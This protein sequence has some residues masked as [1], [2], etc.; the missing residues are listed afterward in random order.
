MMDLVLPI[1]KPIYS[2]YTYTDNSSASLADAKKRF[3]ELPNT[4]Y[5]VLDISKD[6]A[7]QGFENNE[8]DL[9]VATNAIHATKS[10]SESLANVRKLLA[11]NG[12]FL[13]QELHPQSK[14]I[15][16][17]FGLLDD[18]WLGEQDGRSD[19]PYVGSARWQS[20]LQRAGFTVPVTVLDSEEPHQLNALMIAKPVVISPKPIS[21]A[22]TILSDNNVKSAEALFQQLQCRGYSVDLCQLGDE[23]PESQDIISVLDESAPFFENTS[24]THFKAFQQLLAKLGKSGL[25]WVTRPSQ[26]QCNDPRYAQVIGAAR[27]IR[28]EEFL[29]FATCEVDN[30]ESSLDTIIDVFTHFQRRQENEVF[31]PDFE[32]AIFNGIVHVPRIYPFSFKDESLSG[33][34]ADSRVSLEAEKPGRLSSLG[35]VSRGA[36]E[37]VGNQIEVQVFAAGLSSKVCRSISMCADSPDLPNRTSRKS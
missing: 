28:N 30:L 4:E 26:M 23:L 22:V 35:W 13:L 34:S 1:G 27:S 33:S 31:R 37:L 25:L 9:I 29:D 24:E 14:W 18:W 5:R 10:L 8:Y 11:P 12:R 36:K 7:E 20:E 21:K 19:E 2:K 32:Y 6:P 3:Q 15:N 17:I 16:C